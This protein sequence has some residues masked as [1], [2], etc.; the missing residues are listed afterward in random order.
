MEITAIRLEHPDDVNLVVGQAHFI[1][2][3]EDLHEVLAQ[4]SASRPRPTSPSDSSSCAASATSSELGP[5][6]A[7]Q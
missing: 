6:R 7:A 5:P 4:S 3:V 1:K 2:T